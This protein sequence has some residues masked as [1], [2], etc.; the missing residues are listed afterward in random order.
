MCAG[1]EEAQESL[2]EEALS[3]LWSESEMTEEGSERCSISFYYK[4]CIIYFGCAVRH[5]G[6]LFPYQ[7]SN[8]YSLQRKHRVPAAVLPGKPQEAAFLIPKEE[9]GGHA[10]QELRVPLK[11]NQEM[12][13]LSK[14]PERIVALP[15][16]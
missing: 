1:L 13:S 4:K 16:P 15:T 5:V 7:R 10:S 8:P 9:E 6:S 2:T 14:F 3:W 11:E 12:N